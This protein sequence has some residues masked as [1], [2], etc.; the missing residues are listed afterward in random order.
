M[1][2]TDTALDD[3][4]DS[5]QKSRKALELKS[6]KGV[7]GT[8]WKRALIIIALTPV[9]L[10]LFGYFLLLFPKPMREFA[11]YAF[12]GV[13]VFMA[14]GRRFLKGHS[15]DRARGVADSIGARE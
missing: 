1:T 5:N 4:I 6:Y 2:D 11:G 12:W 14:F 3:I 9:V 8:T 10:L 7:G 15:P 13:V